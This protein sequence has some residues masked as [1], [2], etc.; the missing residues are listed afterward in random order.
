MGDPAAKRLD[1][2]SADLADVLRHAD[3]LL[4]EWAR[5]GATVRAQVARE[6]DQVATAVAD[7]TGGAIERAASAQLANLRVELAQLEARLR[8]ASRVT[9]DQR[10]HERRMLAGIAAGIA[11]AVAL[12]VVLVARSPS[13]SPAMVV[14]EPVRI[15]PASIP[16]PDARPADAA[17][18]APPDAPPPPVDAAPHAVKRR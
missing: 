11:V 16:P 14:P 3:A 1:D 6:A 12:L 7:A 13:A 9:A 8:A 10:V 5:F 15:E 4:D 18:D 17:V 2:I